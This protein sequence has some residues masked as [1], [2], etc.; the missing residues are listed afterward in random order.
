MQKKKKKQAEMMKTKKE[1][2]YRVAQH[3]KGLEKTNVKELEV[4]MEAMGRIAGVFFLFYTLAW[5]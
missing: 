1:S 3:R 2:E 4:T 5:F